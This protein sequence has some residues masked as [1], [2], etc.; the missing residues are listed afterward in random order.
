MH[1]MKLAIDVKAV[2]IVGEEP[3]DSAS[4]LANTI[5]D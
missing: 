2:M 1:A 3:R 5:S 4:V